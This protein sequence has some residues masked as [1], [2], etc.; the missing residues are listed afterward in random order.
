MLAYFFNT[1]TTQTYAT[2]PSLPFSTDGDNF[3]RNRIK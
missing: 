1:Y 2:S 3:S